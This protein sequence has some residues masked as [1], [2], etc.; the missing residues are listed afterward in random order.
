MAVGSGPATAQL[1]A[2]V[3]AWSRLGCPYETARALSEADDEKALRRGLDECYRLGARPL[4]TMVS[5]IL[6]ERGAS[7]VPRGPRPSTRENPAQLTSREMEVLRLV[8][9]GLRNGDIAQQLFLSPKTVGHH[10]SS[11]LRKLSVRTCGEAA[12]EGMRLGLLDTRQPGPPG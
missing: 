1:V 7:D 9:V 12:A 10:V 4:A 11:V 2:T 6:R 8:S 3:A 5:R